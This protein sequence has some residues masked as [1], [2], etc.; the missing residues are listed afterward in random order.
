MTADKNICCNNMCAQGRN[1]PH[2]PAQPPTRREWLFT[3]GALV[4]AVMVS[5]ALSG[6]GPLVND[7][8]NQ[9]AADKAANETVPSEKRLYVFT[10]AETGCQYVSAYGETLYPRLG[11][12]GHQICREVRN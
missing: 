3:V 5:F 7:A 10:D 2:R 8:A 4:I 6:C 11:R 12:D 1:C 9:K